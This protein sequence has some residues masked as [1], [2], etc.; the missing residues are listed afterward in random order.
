MVLAAI[1]NLVVVD[2]LQDSLDQ[3][4]WATEDDTVHFQNIKGLLNNIGK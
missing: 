4:H 1:R 3:D 2:A